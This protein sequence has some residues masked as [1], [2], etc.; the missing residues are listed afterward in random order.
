MRPCNRRKG[1]GGGVLYLAVSALLSFQVSARAEDARMA[2]PA[3]ATL[4]QLIKE[5]LAVV[6]ELAQAEHLVR[7]EVER[8]PQA[9]ALPDPM[10]QLGIQ[11]DGFSSIEIGKMP[12]SYISMMV[13]ETFPW[14]GKL[15]LGEEVAKLGASQA[16]QSALR[17]RLSTEADVR[18]AYLDL[19]LAR[20]RAALLDQLETL[21]QKSLGVARVRYEAGDG[22]QSDLLRS[23]LELSRIAQRRFALQAEERA[24][25]EA[26][27]RLRNHRPQEPIET[28]THIRGLL[29]PA[30]LERLFAVPERALTN[31]PELASARLGVTRATRAVDLAEKSYFP[32]LTVGA[33]I[34]YRGS[35]PPMWLATVG[36]P[37]PVFAGSKQNRA[38]AESHALT[39]ASR[40]RA[41]AVEQVLRL[42]SRERH[43]VFKA[44][45]ST[46]QLY[47]Q[48]LLVRSEATAESTLSQYVVGKVSLVSVLEANAGL[49]A[50]QTSY[51]EA[52]AAAHRILV[53]ENELSLAPVA[54]L[55]PG[56]GRE[57]MSAADSS[58]AGSNYVSRGA[59][60]GGGSGM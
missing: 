22:T 16:K 33:G 9:G 12:T 41:A 8:A 55:A 21:S 52:I 7:A 5:S 24:R 43:A 17:V 45:L 34:M 27:N 26:L 1:P 23:E 60:G 20:D 4:S 11:N 32:D 44:L 38:V 47:D 37:M 30:E 15:H 50:D 42:R 56:G 57:S 3:D 49:I 40:S 14:P 25:L 19:L 29:A 59:P 51:L 39:N 2:L 28:S 54:M 35:M 13:S 53:A 6:P 58:P 36:G 46:V 18:R 10:L 31:S 48:G